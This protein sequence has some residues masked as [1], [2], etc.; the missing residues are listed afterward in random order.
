LFNILFEQ[1]KKL[2]STAHQLKLILKKY[3]KRPI[4]KPTIKRST[5][6]SSGKHIV[7]ASECRGEVYEIPR[8]EC[9][10]K[11][12]GQTKRSLSTQLKQH[13]SDTV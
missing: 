2:S 13:H 6:L 4:F 11:F 8:G 7:S 10:H 3:R 5:M 1:A 12:M 9:E